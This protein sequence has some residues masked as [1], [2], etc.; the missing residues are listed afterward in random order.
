MSKRAVV[1]MITA[2]T[3]L[4][5]VPAA[6]PAK[7]FD[8]P[9]ISENSSVLSFG[10]KG[11]KKNGEFKPK[12]ILYVYVVDE[13]FA[14]YRADGSP[15]DPFIEGRTDDYPW[16]DFEGFPFD[17]NKK[18]KF[19]QTVEGGPPT[20]SGAPRYILK[21][22]GRIKKDKKARG[23][24]RAQVNYEGGI[25]TGYCGDDQPVEWNTNWVNGV[26]TER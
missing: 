4:L 2:F 17:V 23:T 6:A 1:V 7:T 13:Y 25:D 15:T 21:F 26:P 19:S 3:V 10:A 8:I 12:K 9:A 24:Y 18:G 20:S 5:L 11:K 22:R 14:C 16:G